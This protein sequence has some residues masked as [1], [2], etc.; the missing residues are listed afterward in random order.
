[1]STWPGKGAQDDVVL[2]PGL[3]VHG[4]LGSRAERLDA[5]AVVRAGELGGKHSE[6]GQVLPVIRT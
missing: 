6:V 5:V 2:V 1:M 3:I 4:E